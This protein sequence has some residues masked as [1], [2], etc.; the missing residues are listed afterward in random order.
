MKRLSRIFRRRN[1]EAAAPVDGRVLDETMKQL[2]ESVREILNFSAAGFADEAFENV[3]GPVWGV[4]I[5][6]SLLTSIQQQIQEAVRPV[7]LEMCDL[8]KTKEPAGSKDLGI[9][10]L[11]IKLAIWELAF[12]IERYKLNMIVLQISRLAGTNHLSTVEAAGHA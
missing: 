10:Y 11:I 2:D 4:Q 12:M 3:V 7:V 6:K 9:D 8:F 1:I 5:G